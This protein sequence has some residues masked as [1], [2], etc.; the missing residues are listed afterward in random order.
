MNPPGTG[1]V[2]PATAEATARQLSWLDGELPRWVAEGLVT[3]ESAAAIRGRYAASHRFSLIRLAVTLGS[4]F[5]VVG[6]VW[7]VAANL[8]ALSPL[9]RF[10]LVALVWL[11][12]LAGAEL[13]AARRA[14]GDDR[15][16]PLAAGLRL[17]AAGA[18]GALVFQTAQSLQVPAGTPA[19]LGIWA[20][21][22]LVH[23]YAV[24]S[25]LPGI[26]GAG[27]LALW[28]L[29]DVVRDAGSERALSL[30]LLA[31]GLVAVAVGLLH[32][33]RWWRPMSMPWRELGAFLVLAGAFVAVV[34]TGQ[35]AGRMSWLLWVTLVA[36]VAGSA[37][38]LVRG[39]R[40]ARVEAGLA[41][42]GLVVGGILTVWSV[43]TASWSTDRLTA[44]DLTRSLVAVVLYLAVATGYAVLGT[45][46]DSWRITGLALA[47]L[48]GF[49]TF[50]AFAV[51]APIFSGAA[52]FILVGLVLIATGVIADRGRRRLA[53]RAK[54]AMA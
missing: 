3:A 22:A 24:R 4:I 38:A 15:G 34:P 23:G 37:W 10:L 39:A 53:A 25:V 16:V 9:A 54:G 18:Y 52:L 11:V 7:L 14:P 28:F 47:G 51:F 8:D 17:L 35:T 49:V 48:T 19:L 41:L 29:V 26:L 12:L 44:G 33:A 40:L 46:R 50:Q 21:G 42:A 1:S 43:D 6:L 20:A 31:A 13:Y 27:L 32:E 30:G 45:L 2:G 5:L 36:G